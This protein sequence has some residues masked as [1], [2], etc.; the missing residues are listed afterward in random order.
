M[1]RTPEA[2]ALL[3]HI[4]APGKADGLCLRVDDLTDAEWMTARELIAAGDVLIEDGYVTVSAT[5][6]ELVTAGYIAA[7]TGETA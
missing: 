7:R 4:I 2:E 1:S 5:I 3:R 6:S